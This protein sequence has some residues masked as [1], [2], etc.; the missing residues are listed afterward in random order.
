MNKIRAILA[1]DENWGIGKSGTLPWPHNRNDQLWFR[2]CTMGGV[3][4]MGKATWDDPD[5]PKPMPG[6]NNVVITSAEDDGNGSYQFVRFE[7]A[8][9]M[10]KSMAELQQVWVIGG[11]RL[12]EACLPFIDELWLSRI[13]GTYDCDTHLPRELIEQQ[14]YISETQDLLDKNLYLE[15]WTKK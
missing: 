3:V 9:P 12:V 14:Y 10:L 1:C 11:A 6:R 4:A 8:E 13:T 7:N 5:M 15:T 2:D